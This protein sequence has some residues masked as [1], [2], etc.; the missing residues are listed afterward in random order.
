MIAIF[1]KEKGDFIED[2]DGEVI[3]FKNVIQAKNWLFE[4]QFRYEVIEELFDFR[5]YDP[6]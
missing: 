6:E 4:N 2:D 3:V 1:D 5:Y